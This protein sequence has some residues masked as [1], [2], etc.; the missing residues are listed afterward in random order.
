VACTRAVGKLTVLIPP[1]LEALETRAGCTTRGSGLDLFGPVESGSCDVDGNP[2]NFATF[3]SDTDRDN[4][5]T[6]LR[7]LGTQN[8]GVGPGWAIQA[9]NAPTAATVTVALGGRAT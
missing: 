5:V 4:W 2:V 6:A 9:D 7:L 3:R 8:F 1:A